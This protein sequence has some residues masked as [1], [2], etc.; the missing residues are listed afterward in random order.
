MLYFRTIQKYLIVP[1][2]GHN[3]AIKASLTFALAK[4]SKPE[5]D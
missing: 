1:K 5:Y 3:R 2:N 4:V